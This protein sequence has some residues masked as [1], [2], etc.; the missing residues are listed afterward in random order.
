MRLSIRHTT[1]Y[2]FEA[3][4]VH[5]LQRLRLTPKSTQGQSIV[6]WSMNFENATTELEYDDQHFNRV[7]L[8]AI[9][10][11]TQEVMIRC[12]GKVDTQDNAGV[13]GRHSGHLPLWSFLR[14]TRFD[15]SGQGGEKDDPEGRA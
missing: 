7:T 8:A 3:P 9:E 6:D 14:Q 10:P 4:V 11:G 12:E 13:I 2:N 1:R 15:P 5:A